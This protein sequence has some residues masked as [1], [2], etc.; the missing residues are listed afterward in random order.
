MVVLQNFPHFPY[1]FRKGG[2]KMYNKKDAP[3]SYEYAELY[4]RAGQV[5]WGYPHRSSSQR[6]EE[7][8]EFNQMIDENYKPSEITDYLKKVA[9][10]EMS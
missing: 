10:G 6:E 4:K 7:I 5:G 8:A 2:D 1:V 3:D 9:R